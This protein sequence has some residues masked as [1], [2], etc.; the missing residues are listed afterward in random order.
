ML[1]DIEAR[2]IT[3]ASINSKYLKCYKRSTGK[4]RMIDLISNESLNIMYLKVNI[5]KY[6]SIWLKKLNRQSLFNLK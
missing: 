4:L 1:K 2:S 6:I 3:R 5:G